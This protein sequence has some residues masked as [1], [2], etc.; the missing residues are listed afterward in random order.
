MA[1]VTRSER[2]IKNSEI[3][4]TDIGPGEYENE[5]IKE[6][7]RILHKISNIY[8]HNGGNKNN[9]QINIPFNSTCGRAP[10]IKINDT[11]GPGTYTDINPYNNTKRKKTELPLLTNE[12]IF[13]E[14]N[15]NLIPKLK[16]ESK[17]F[18]S[19]E[20]RFKNNLKIDNNE[21]IGPGKYQ[22]G[23]SFIKE[24]M[25]NK[26]NT[27]YGKISKNKVSSIC[28]TSDNTV[29]TI[30]DKNKKFEFVN[31]EI[32]EIKKIDFKGSDV[33]PGK[34]D[35]YPKWT[36]HSLNWNY[37]LKKEDKYN[38][39]KNDVI[40]S[41]NKQKTAEINNFQNTL[42]TRF[43]KSFDKKLKKNKSNNNILDE[44]QNNTIKYKVFKRFI[45]DRK[46]MH[47]DSLEKI[48]DYN[49][50]ILDIK[51]NDTPGPGFYDNKLIKGPVSIFNS[52]KSQNFGSN[53][54]Q[55]FKINR[56]ND[57]IGP[58]SYFLEKNKYEPKFE[59]SIH[60]KK[61]QN[62]IEKQKDIGI[63]IYNYRKDNISKCP[64][65]GQ[66]DLGHNFIKKDISNVKSFGILSERFK[67]EKPSGNINEMELENV[68]RE[69]KD[70]VNNKYDDRVKI[71]IDSKY[72]Q[73]KKEEEE[74]E[75]KR[76][77]HYRD[78]KEPAVGS[79]SPEVISSIS[80]Q[81]LSRLNP[82]RNKIAP[83]NI[84]NTRFRNEP[85]RPKKEVELPGPGKYEIEN[86]YNAL[87][88]SKKNYR[89][90]GIGPQRESYNKGSIGP[91]LYNQEK[92][93]SWNKKTFNI[94]FMNT[95][96]L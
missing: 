69:N 40:N 39:F 30:P 80:Y 4:S 55:F 58:G 81:V 85:K 49:D 96:S 33:G 37:G 66:Y 50:K 79:Y 68:N 83:F 94:L 88:N 32:K 43:N 77:D 73:S 72:I 44:K 31:G 3:N 5:E 42:L 48:K 51:Y 29:A 10:L 46:R 67:T 75:K 18:L 19:S 12:I 38:S 21:N 34:Y 57:S 27:R 52:N 6:E 13:V 24:K 59:T 16:N 56:E 28:R 63:Y 41:F 7:A 82:Y 92:Q 74:Q 11:P 87:Y 54:P 64:G 25:V 53:T 62:N 91:G 26:Y 89:I 17:G 47:A 45:K 84:M 70:Y 71:K 60:V 36:S 93:N 15:G 2:K 22:L 76:R 8:T 86:A 23:K 78:I 65:P 95:N 61:P 9:L 90:F 1:F 35:I 20:K 14:E